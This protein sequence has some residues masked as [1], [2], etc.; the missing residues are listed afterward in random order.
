M[1]FNKMLVTQIPT[2]LVGYCRALLCIYKTALWIPATVD[3]EIYFKKQEC[4][5][6]HS[7]KCCT[8]DTFWLL[9]C[10]PWF[11]FS[12]SIHKLCLTWNKNASMIALLFL[13][14]ITQKNQWL[15]FLYP[16][17]FFSFWFKSLFM[18][19]MNAKFKLSLFLFLGE[20]SLFGIL[21]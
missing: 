13:F 21:K 2:K 15:H 7:T 12:N 14:Y 3:D 4:V 17:F 18:E 1:E 11:F 20:P 6:L 10:P 5:Y 16:I 8:T 19:I 9:W